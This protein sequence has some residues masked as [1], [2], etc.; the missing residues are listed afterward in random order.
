MA[1]EK[2]AYE[3]VHLNNCLHAAVASNFKRASFTMQA[4]VKESFVRFCILVK[5]S[6]TILNDL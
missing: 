4:E 1:Y 6:R 5:T 3:K 2:F